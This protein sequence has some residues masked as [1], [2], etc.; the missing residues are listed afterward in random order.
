MNEEVDGGAGDADA[1]G[2]SARREFLRKAGRYAAVTP[3]V[4]ATM[5]TVLSKPAL[6]AGSGSRGGNGSNKGKKKGWYKNGK[7]N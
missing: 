6:A 3:P 1:P 7:R 4:I 5:M 2:S